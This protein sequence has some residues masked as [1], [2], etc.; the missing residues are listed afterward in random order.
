M[1]KAIQIFD[2]SIIDSHRTETE[3]NRAYAHGKS[4][5]QWPNSLHNALPARA[6]D[7]APYPISWGN[8]AK[9]LARFYYL[10]GVLKAVS[11]YENIKIRQGCD[12]DSD[13]LFADQ[14]FDDLP[15][16]ELSSEEV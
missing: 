4:K 14:T 3:Q 15:H 6:A 16:I 13:G 7:I 5:L 9:D 8:N 1:Q 10:Q 11:Y 12:W 2:F